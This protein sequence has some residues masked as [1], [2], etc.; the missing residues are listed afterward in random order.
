MA[1]LSDVALV[2]WFLVVRAPQGSVV[3]AVYDEVAAL[4]VGLET[5]LLV[6]AAVVLVE[7]QLAAVF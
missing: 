2:S 1:C 6:L 5:E 4:V 7:D 3:L